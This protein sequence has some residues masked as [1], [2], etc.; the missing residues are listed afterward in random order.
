MDIYVFVVIVISIVTRT[1]SARI[2]AV[3]PTPS[4]SHQIVFRPLTQELVKRGHEV[5]VIT[6]DPN[7]APGKAPVNLTEIDVSNVSYSNWHTE[8]VNADVGKS[9]DLYKQFNVFLKVFTATFE[10]QIQ[11]KTVKNMIRNKNNIRF[12]LL[13]LETC[14]RPTLAFSHIYKA[15]VISISSFGPT[16]GTYGFLGVPTHPLL[17]PTFTNQRLYNL[18]YWEKLKE[19]FYYYFINRMSALHEHEQNKMF[20][21]HFGQDIPPLSELY[22]NI[23]MFFQNMKSLLM[24]NPPVPSSV[25][26]MGGVHLT[27][28]KPLLQPNITDLF[29][30]LNSS[31]NGVIYVSF[32]TNVK[33]SILPPEKI[34]MMIKV[35]S[36]LPYDVLWKMDNTKLSGVSKNV[37]VSEWLPQADLLTHKNIKV[38]ITQG[39][40]QSTDEAVS[41]G[42]PL[43]GIPMFADQW[44]NVEKYVHH[45]IGIK[46]DWISLTENEF[47]GAIL[48]V[49]EDISYLKN[50]RRFRKILNDQPQSPMERAILWIEHVLQHGGAKHLRAPAANMSWKEYY[51][52]DL[53]GILLTS[54]IVALLSMFFFLKLFCLNI[55]VFLRSKHRK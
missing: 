4:I 14:M 1:D 40:K 12:D 8:V 10:N 54:A 28:P 22:N 55:L 18:T 43:I 33:S 34:Q 42:V 6:T 46:L 25:V 48:T 37:K 20:K 41:A 27:V 15:P 21:K 53:I 16:L 36:R 50:I 24:D 29:S 17:Y 52:L 35:F 9:N 11:V 45:K 44:F 7:Y 30:F 39:G 5:V 26:Y 31:K 49:A 23:D 51:E 13:L 2:L 19:L 47:R 32:G 38:F 3:F